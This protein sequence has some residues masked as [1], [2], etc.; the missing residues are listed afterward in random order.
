M[1]RVETLEV[2]NACVNQLDLRIPQSEAFLNSVESAI[3]YLQEHYYQELSHSRVGSLPVTVHS[4][5]HTHIDVAWKWTLSQT[6]QKAVRSFLT[7]SRLM[8][9]YP[10]YKFMSSQPQLYQYVKE[11][12]PKL[13][14]EIKEMVKQGRWETEGA[15]W[16]EAD[17][18]LSSGES[19]I[20]QILY[21][22]QFFRQEFGTEENEILWLPDVFGYSVAL[23]QILKKSGIRYF[24]TT[25]LGWNE[26]NQIP[27]DTMMWQGLDGSEILTY[28]ITTTNYQSYPEL[29]YKKTFNTTYNGLQNAKQI[30]G[31]WQRFQDQSLS[32]DVLTCYGYGDGGGGPT[33]Q[34]LEENRRLEQGICG[35]PVTKQTFTRDFFHILEH[36]LT[37]KKIPRWCGELYLEFH[38]GTYT[39]MARNKKN[40]RECEFLNGD[41]E[42]FSVLAGYDGGTLSYPKKQLEEV[43]K[44]LMLNQFHDILPGSSIKEVYQDSDLQYARIRQI[45]HTIIREAQ[46]NIVKQHGYQPATGIESNCKLAVFNTVGFERTGLVKVN[47]QVSIP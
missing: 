39:S 29:N 3:Q 26:N 27:H 5:G 8:K 22:K 13:Y 2:L 44:L 12:A 21:G 20:R 40:N 37:G 10:E 1:G 23:P 46:K 41:A 32:R 30:M 34:M 4:I 36:N 43:W 31:T 24:M 38:R 35:C 33:A 42:F 7:V 11:S 16:L 14:G 9:Q 25:K 19:L 15:M 47:E 6:R 18:N 45:D 17:C 28:F